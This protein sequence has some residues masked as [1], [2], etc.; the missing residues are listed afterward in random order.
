MKVQARGLTVLDN[1]SNT[2]TFTVAQLADVAPGLMRLHTAMQEEPLP[3]TLERYTFGRFFSALFGEVKAAEESRAEY[4]KRNCSP[5]MEQIL[6]EDGNPLCDG[7]GV[8]TT[9]QKLDPR[10][11]P[12]ITF[13][14]TPEWSALMATTV[15]F[16]NF[17]LL[18]RYIVENQLSKLSKVTEPQFIALEPFLE[19]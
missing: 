7:G 1:P 15:E 4:I 8:P 12:L 5:L 11:E 9:R 18:P 16:T 2:M 19:N 3:T 17:K 14:L 10:G 13:V 6:G